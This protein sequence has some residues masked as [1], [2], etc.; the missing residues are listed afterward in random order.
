MEKMLKI[1]QEDQ[2]VLI[3]LHRNLCCGKSD[4]CVVH[5]FLITHDAHMVSRISK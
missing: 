2:L 1:T 3:H 5:T 4:V